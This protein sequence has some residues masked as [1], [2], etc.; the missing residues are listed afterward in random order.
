MLTFTLY[1]V[2]FAALIASKKFLGDY[3]SPPAIFLFFWCFAVGTLMLEWVS[4]DPLGEPVWWAI[5]GS[6][7]S[8]LLGCLVPVFL[9]LS[10]HGWRT[11]GPRLQVVNKSRYELGLMV[12]FG[13]GLFGFAVQLVHLQMEVGLGTF[14]SDPQRAR[15]MHSNVKYLGFFNILNLANFVLGALYLCL[16][17]RPHKWVLGM[18]LFALVTTFVSTDRTRFFYTVIWTF[19]AVVY[20]RWRVHLSVRVALA[21]LATCGVL[22]GFFLLIAKIYVKQAYDDNMEYINISPEYSAL[23]DPYIYL[24]GSFPVLQRVL[25]DPQER[26]Y[27]KYTFEP[28]V[29]SIEV[30]YPDLSRAEIVGKFYRVPVELNVAT[31]LQPFYQDFGW[32]GLFF[33]PFVFGLITTSIYFAMRQAKSLFLVYLS[34]LLAFCT[35][36]SIFVNHYIQTATFFFILVGYVFSRFVSGKHTQDPAQFRSGIFPNEP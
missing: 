14:L 8:F 34:S 11:A 5:W 31:Y 28:F 26:T 24:T 19:F 12:L 9:A 32:P 15:E 27:G 18:L 33:F 3:F 25:E 4:F 1:L 30:I 35:T 16:F 7:A 22:I 21:G 36:I 10:R 13:L 29:K 17:K 2:A 23:I 20:V 6:V